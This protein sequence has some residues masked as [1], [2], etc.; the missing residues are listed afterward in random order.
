MM[1]ITAGA[2][3][4][5]QALFYPGLVNA[6]SLY[7]EL[8][9]TPLEIARG[10]M[11]L[12]PGSNIGPTAPERA[13][14]SSSTTLGGTSVTIT[15]GELNRTVPLLYASS[16]LVMGFIPADM[17]AGNGTYSVTYGG[18]T[19]SR[20]VRVV[21]RAF[22]IFTQTGDPD[23]PA[24]AQNVSPQNENVLNTFLESARPGQTMVLWGTGVGGSASDATVLVGGKP[25]PA[26]YAGVSGCCG[27]M[28]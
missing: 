7:S 15:V 22:G 9:S 2:G 28:D 4:S 3:L 26:S 18:S 16:S 8:S 11:F 19:S 25:A 21:E 6:A 5:Q 17:P 27:G 13:V 20:M 12:I 23:G 24:I 14:D 10:A 1:A